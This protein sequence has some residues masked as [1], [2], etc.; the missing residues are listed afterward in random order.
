MNNFN[1]F[2]VAIVI[3]L[4]G[5]LLS[6]CQSTQKLPH[7]M[8]K[9]EPKIALVLGGGS[10]KGFA[11][12]G[13]IRVLEQEKI[14]IHMIVGTSVGSLIGGIYAANPDSFQLEWLAFKIDKNDIL[15]LSIIYSK[16]GPA[17]GARLESFVEQTVAIKKIEDTKIPFFPIATDLNTGET[18]IMEK[19]SLSKAIRASSAIPGIFVPV[20]FGNRLLVDGGVTNSTP[21]DIARSKGAD[22]VI[23]INLLKDIKDYNINSLVDIIGQSVNIMMHQSNKTKLQHADVII[24][25]DTKGTALF[26]FSQKKMLMEE[27]IKAAKASLPKIKEVIERFRQ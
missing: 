19:G 10:A 16:L 11:H 23:A 18:I 25:P 22:I 12:I 13:V 3:V 17:Q 4:T 8:K 6:S 24:E 26:D 15:D 5:I 9:G 2:F 1:K 27:G 21:C 20:T 14:P 7:T